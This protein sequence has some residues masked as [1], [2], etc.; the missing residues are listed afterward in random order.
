MINTAGALSRRHEPVRHRNR[1]ANPQM[2]VDFEIFVD[3][4]LL[5]S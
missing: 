1:L 5:Q 2:D 3:E 4:R